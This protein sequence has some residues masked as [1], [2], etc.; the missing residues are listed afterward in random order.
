MESQKSSE[1]AVVDDH[2]VR[3]RE[4][5]ETVPDTL[6][7][8]GGTLNCSRDMGRHMLEPIEMALEE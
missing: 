6:R 1:P 5:H 2:T 4:V 3:G 7:Q 8:M